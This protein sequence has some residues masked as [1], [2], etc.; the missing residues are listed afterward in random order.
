[1]RAKIQRDYRKFCKN[2]PR[3]KC[4]PTYLFQQ[5]KQ[6]ATMLM[7][8]TPTT[9]TP[10]ILAWR[11]TSSASKLGSGGKVLRTVTYPL[12]CVEPRALVTTHEYQPLCLYNM[13]FSLKV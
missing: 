6:M 10:A 12:L 13:D 2:E 9:T 7:T 5:Q 1:M 11:V 8:A 4:N 3:Q